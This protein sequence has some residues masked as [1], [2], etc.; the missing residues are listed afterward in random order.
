M[1][2]LEIKNPI[3]DRTYKTRLSADYSSGTAMTVESNV[4]FSA[5]DYLIVG[6]PSEE[7]TEGKK[8]DS[9]SGSTALTLASTLNFSHGKGTSIYKSPWDQISIERRTSSGGS[10]SIVSTSAIQWDNPNNLTLYFDE[11]A[12]DDYGYRFRFYNSI[13]GKYSE[14]SPTLEGS[15]FTRAQAGYLISQVRLLANDIERKI[16]TD[17]EILR[18]FNRA[19]DIIYTHNPKYWFLLIDS[20][21]AGTGIA[22]T[23]SESVYSLATYTTFG[24]LDTVRYHYN[25]GG[26]SE[27]YHLLKKT[28]VEFDDVASNLNE[29]ADDWAY[30]YKLLPAD[31]SSEN[32]YIQIFPKTK[33][34]SVGTLYPNYYEKMQDLNSVDDE[35]QVPLP[36]LLED[37][38]IGQIERIK[39]NEQKAQYYEKI[40]VSDNPDVTP[41]GLVM[42]DK[43][44]RAQKDSVGQ[45]KNLW[46]FR[47][48]KAI[49]RLFGN[50][51]RMNRDY[52]RENYMD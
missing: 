27:L 6:E 30:I 36:D 49:P 20:Y 7:L 44:D 24:H 32:G 33:N 15:G 16:V 12:T 40:L 26:T 17:D 43:M 19:Q 21:K 29:T 23:A 35:T 3:L 25:S 51:R 4:S 48:Q 38:A 14:Y 28:S 18:F 45:P 39:G 22:A 2:K 11:D 47:G 46:N 52:I 37:F 50:R 41:S 1:R 8:L 5:N 31:E 10:F 42:L 13:T 34:T 9:K